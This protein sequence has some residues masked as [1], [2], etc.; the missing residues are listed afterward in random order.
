MITL[1]KGLFQ[2]TW[3]ILL[4]SYGLCKIC[5]TNVKGCTCLEQKE[6]DLTLCCP[7]IIGNRFTISVRVDEAAKITCM[8]RSNVT[9]AEIVDVLKQM[10]LF[11]P[12]L[13]TGE[14]RKRLQ[15][16][17]ERCN[18]PDMSYQQLMDDIQVF[19]V[20]RVSISGHDH[21]P[22]DRTLLENLK[23][24]NIE[25]R[26]VPSLDLDETFFSQQATTKKVVFSTI[27]NLTIKIRIIVVY[28]ALTEKF[29]GN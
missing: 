7:T 17:F 15:F 4:C 11:E 10:K 19:N 27:K 5:D 23:A 20:I 3:L 24:T 12:K 22:V 14:S 18:L 1:L 2:V 28:Q 29:S 21:L 25:I 26:N 6:N 13:E 9:G 8:Q 16:F